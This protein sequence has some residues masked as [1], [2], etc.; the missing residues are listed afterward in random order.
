MSRSTLKDISIDFLQLTAVGKSFEAFQVYAS[1]N[2]IHHNPFFAG[3]A[4]SL[5]SAMEENAKQNPD[6]V[7]EI[8]R[9]LEDGD[10][11]AVYSHIRQN[12]AESGF[13]VMHILRFEDSKI[14][15]LW[16][17]GQAVPERMVNEHGMF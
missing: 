6:K 2:F 13:A 17:I 7:F 15:E 5:A 11:I 4:N 8:K 3:D 16:D 10:F 9:I 1:E 12:P 14:A